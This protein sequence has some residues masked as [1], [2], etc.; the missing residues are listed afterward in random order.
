MVIPIIRSNT[1]LSAALAVA[2]HAQGAVRAPLVLPV[3]NVASAGGG[4]G[5]ATVVFAI[6][7]TGGSGEDPG[8][9]H[10]QHSDETGDDSGG[11]L[12]FGGLFGGFN[13]NG[14]FV[15]WLLVVWGCLRFFEFDIS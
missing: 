14:R 15:M 2:V 4:L 13:G 6:P 12:H 1:N 9:G 7:L 3:D 11:E 10:G 5:A 8:V